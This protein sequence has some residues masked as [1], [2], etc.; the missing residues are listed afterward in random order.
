[1]VS[2]LRAFTIAAA[3][4]VAGLVA[5]VALL[6]FTAATGDRVAA[7]TG[8]LKWALLFLPAC[9]AVAGTWVAIGARNARSDASLGGQAAL[10]GLAAALVVLLFLAILSEQSG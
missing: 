7:I 8:S 6:A 9:L 3:W 5:G 10:F 4:I 1:M 2:P